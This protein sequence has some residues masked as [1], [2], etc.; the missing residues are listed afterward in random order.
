MINISFISQE[1]TLFEGEAKMVVMDGQEGQL[2]IVKGHSPLL[3][4]LKPGP[5]R[6]IQESGEQVFFTNGGFAEV[7]PESITILVDSAVRADDLDEAKILKA[8]EEAE[9]L[10][11]DKKD[12]KD[13]AEV[14]SQL[15]Q[16]L[17]QLRAIEALKKNVKLKS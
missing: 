11:K 4:I 6:M 9:K 12:Q 5:V 1:K 3:A 13:F 14:S 16:S 7:Q 17:S 2:G 10:L 8:K 15:N